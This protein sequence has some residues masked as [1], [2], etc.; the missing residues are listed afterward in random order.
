MKYSTLLVFCVLTR[1][2]APAKA[3]KQKEV[4]KAKPEEKKEEPEAE[5][6]EAPAENGKAEEEVLKCCLFITPA[7]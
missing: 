2:A 4:A 5:K 6:E 7:T 1:Q 3:K